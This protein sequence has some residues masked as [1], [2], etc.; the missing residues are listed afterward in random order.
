MLDLYLYKYSSLQ[1]FRKYFRISI[2]QPVE[3]NASIIIYELKLL[4]LSKFCNSK[5]IYYNI[6]YLLSQNFFKI[7]LNVVK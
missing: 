7:G 1:L 5:N 6:L 4:A 2:S 3:A